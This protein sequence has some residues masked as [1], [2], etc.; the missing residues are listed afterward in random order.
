MGLSH[1]HGMSDFYNTVITYHEPR[2]LTERGS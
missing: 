1:V 2:F